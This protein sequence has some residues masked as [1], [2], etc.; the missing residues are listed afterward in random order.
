MTLKQISILRFLTESFSEDFSYLLKTD[1]DIVIDLQAVRRYFEAF[2]PVHQ[3]Q[4]T[5]SIFCAHLN[6]PAA[7]I[8]F[9]DK[10]FVSYDEYP[11]K[12]F[13]T[14]CSGAGYLITKDL[15]A[16]LYETSQ[17]VR[18]FWIDDILISGILAKAAGDVK[19]IQIP[20]QGLMP[21]H[22][23]RDVDGNGVKKMFVH[24]AQDLLTFE[25]FSKGLQNRRGK[26]SL[27]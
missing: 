19:L 3:P 2:F 7:V 23:L 8:R 10:Y 17:H 12:L 1:D 6:P 11:A 25:L 22:K 27:S 15:V 16:E 20:R 18:T 24:V 9:V 21:L 26:N 4:P 5:R 14:Y 13:P